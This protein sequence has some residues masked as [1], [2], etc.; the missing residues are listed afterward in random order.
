MTDDR[1]TRPV[2][3]RKLGK[4]KVKEVMKRPRTARV[5]MSIDELLERMLGKIETCLPVVDGD[6]KLLG[7]VTE[8]DLI[9]VLHPR[10]QEQLSFG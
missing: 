5:D 7:I 10:F 6:K 8:S 4:I 1:I 2:N 9:Q 3:A